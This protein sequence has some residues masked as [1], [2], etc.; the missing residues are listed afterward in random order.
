MP[1]STEHVKCVA[2]CEN[3]NKCIWN[4]EE[5]Y[6]TC[7]RKD[8]RLQDPR[9]SKDPSRSLESTDAE[10]MNAAAPIMSQLPEW[11]TL[12]AK[13]YFGRNTGA[14]NIQQSSSPPAHRSRAIS[15]AFPDVVSTQQLND[16]RQELLGR[17]DTLAF[18][19]EELRLSS[20]PPQDS[21]G[22][23]G[24][25]SSTGFQEEIQSVR[26]ASTDKLDSIKSAL[27]SFNARV[28]NVEGKISPLQH[29][30]ESA[31]AHLKTVQ[32]Q[33]E[34][35]SGRVTWGEADLALF[36]AQID[37]FKSESN[38]K[39][40]ELDQSLRKQMD[41]HLVRL[42]ADKAEY[43]L[44]KARIGPLEQRMETLA[45]TYE[46]LNSQV[47]SAFQRLDT[48]NINFERSA[49]SMRAALSQL[50]QKVGSLQGELSSRDFHQSQ[51]TIREN[52]T[53]H[54]PTFADFREEMDMLKGRLNGLGK[55]YLEDKISLRRDLAVHENTI[56]KALPTLRQLSQQFE[57]F[58]L[59]VA[60]YIRDTTE[61][62]KKVIALPA[63]DISSSHQLALLD[64]TSSSRD[65]L[66]LKAGSLGESGAHNPRYFDRSESQQ[67]A[68]EE[69]VGTLKALLTQSLTLASSAPACRA[70][71][72]RLH[73]KVWAS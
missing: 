49:F 1:R 31:V 4:A 15:P 26:Q 17:L 19:L 20:E 54:M 59:D 40:D 30:R 10:V 39:L 9:H 13:I 62:L 8:H 6:T 27:E 35:F 3:G 45:Q 52:L 72:E 43:A 28:L 2:I 58:R 71:Q 16:V 7:P 57:Q 48:S 55:L 36:Q 33:I 70:S 61:K 25:L 66:V 53:T 47:T 46:S 65:N 21:R 50:E 24:L 63:A 69:Q 22:T 18:G 64:T 60:E 14:A 23:S 42:D 29:E 56:Q 38:N 12:P 67:G 51:D 73:R 34:S 37:S 5:G 44:T 11:P 32:E 68:D 41:A